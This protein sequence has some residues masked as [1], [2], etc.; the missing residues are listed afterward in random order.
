[1]LN[2]QRWRLKKGN[3]ERI[4]SFPCVNGLRR[5]GQVSTS[6]TAAHKS[7]VHVS[8]LLI[9]ATYIF[10]TFWVQPRHGG[11]TRRWVL[12]LD[13]G[14]RERRGGPQRGWGSTGIYSFP[15]IKAM[16]QCKRGEIGTLHP[17]GTSRKSKRKQ[18][19]E[20]ETK[21]ENVNPIT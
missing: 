18:R 16:A 4:M 8:I 17:L 13:W 6:T 21:W 5:W 3:R 7:K 12:R 20:R 1:M 9:H 10:L 14:E 11:P 2:K 15:V 19:G